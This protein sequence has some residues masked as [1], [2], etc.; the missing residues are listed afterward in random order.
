M[1]GAVVM[2]IPQIVALTASIGALNIVSLANPLFL[3]AAVALVVMGIATAMG[4]LGDKSKKTA[5][6]IKEVGDQAIKT[7][8]ALEPLR[9]KINEVIEG[10]RTGKQSALDI[11]LEKIRSQYLPEIEKNQCRIKGFG[12]INY[13]R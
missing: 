13:R 4:V 3:A 9:K 6:E 2:L 11:E 10:S 8:D 5:E 12:G 7:L 1:S